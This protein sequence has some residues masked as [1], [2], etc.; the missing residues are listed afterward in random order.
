M[1]LL[2]IA[3]A[4]AALGLHVFPVARDK[5]TRT[6]HGF[7]DAS[8]DPERIRAW[9]TAMPSANPGFYPG[10]SDDAVLDI[11]HGLTDLESFIAWRDRNG[12]PPTYTVRSGSRPEF[13]VHMYFRGGMKDV[14]AWELD[15]CSGQVKSLGGYVLAAG[16]EALHGEK[17]DKPGAPYEVIDGTLGVFAPTPDVVR[18]LK[19]PAVV[20]SNNAKVPKTAWNL[21]VREGQDRTG[22]L[23]EQ[24]GAMRRLGCGVDAIRARMV[25]LNED[26]EIIAD[27]VSED[28]LDSTAANCAKYSVPEPVG[29]VT[30]GGSQPEQPKDWRLHY[31]S[32]EEFDNVKPPQ[33]LVEGILQLQAILMIAAFVGQKKTLLV[34]NMVRSLLTGEPLFGKYKVPKQPSRVLYLGPENGLISFAD[35]VKRLGLR[36]YIGKT[37]FFSTMN[38][39]EPPALS[40]L[41]RQEI[42][43]AVVIIDTLIRYSDGNENDSA[44]MKV[45][46]ESAFRLIRDGAAAV[47][48][49]HHSRKSSTTA[50]DITLENCS[51]GSGELVAFVSAVMGVRTQDPDHAYESSSLIKFVK[52]RDFEA[53]PSSFEVVTDRKTCHMTYVDGSDNAKVTLGNTANKDGKDDE[54]IAVMKANQQLSNVKMAKLLK[55]AGIDRSKEWVRLKRLELGIGGLKAGEM[56]ATL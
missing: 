25:E 35:R 15:G 43:G 8:I 44:A 28:R 11:D 49:L 40:D 31:H 45:L 26:P 24:T 42:E 17:H 56:A 55:D 41:T 50:N 32:L 38:L 30:I 4:H 18:Q 48:V 14:G 54:A 2:E 13:K 6:A 53:N 46:A 33:F 29:T 27:P 34:L 19:K 21:P 52:E 37:L 1:T 20:S 7:K 23:M 47:I 16:S 10:A 12:I 5:S 22:F 9:W 39:A 51:R 36:D 3:L